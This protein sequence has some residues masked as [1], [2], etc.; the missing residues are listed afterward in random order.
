MRQR[1]VLTVTGTGSRL[2]LGISTPL[3]P[4]WG[5]GGRVFFLGGLGLNES[6][7]PIRL[8]EHGG[9]CIVMWI[10]LRLPDGEAE[11]TD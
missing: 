3:K 11:D 6:V 9:V 7:W 2:G 8:M 5:G 1:L 10:Y 4:V